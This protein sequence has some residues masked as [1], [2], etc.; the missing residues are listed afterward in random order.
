LEYK[1]STTNEK[2]IRLMCE[3]KG[4]DVLSRASSQSIFNGWVKEQ[5]VNGSVTASNEIVAT[6]LI[7]ILRYDS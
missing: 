2:N 3:Q 6:I 1:T 4:N 7:K 5:F